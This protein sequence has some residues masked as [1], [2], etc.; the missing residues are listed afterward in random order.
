M[1]WITNLI[2]AAVFAASLV[3]L[4]H[5]SAQSPA[6]QQLQQ[7]LGEQTQWLADQSTGDG[8]NQYLQIGRFEAATRR[9]K[10]RPTDPHCTGSC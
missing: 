9:A 10:T 1:R 8:W 3:F 5:V 6:K 2:S 4:A 7:A